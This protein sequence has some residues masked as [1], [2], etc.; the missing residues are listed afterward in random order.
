MK[1]LALFAF[2]LVSS[3]SLADE[4]K[5]SAWSDIKSG[6]MKAIRGASKGIKKAA[7]KMD[8]KIE[9]NQKED[10]EEEKKENAKKKK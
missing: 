9:E 2:L 8:K 7:D 4:E 3:L 1:F 5:T 10:Q 6:T